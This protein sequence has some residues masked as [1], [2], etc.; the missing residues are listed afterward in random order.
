MHS[1]H[2]ANALLSKRLMTWAGTLAK[3]WTWKI[4]GSP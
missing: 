4:I 2:C 3:V 1:E